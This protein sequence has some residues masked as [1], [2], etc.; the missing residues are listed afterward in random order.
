MPT[1]VA[2]KVIMRGYS[3]YIEIRYGFIGM[4]KV[5][6]NTPPPPANPNIDASKK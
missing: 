4:P 5:M 2:A 1:R 3:G 6:K